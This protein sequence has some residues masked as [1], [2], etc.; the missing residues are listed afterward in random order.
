MKNTEAYLSEIYGGPLDDASKA[1]MQFF[2]ECYKGSLGATML[3]FGGGPA[4]YSVVSAARSCISIH[5]ADYSQANLTEIERWKS[6]GADAFDWRH[7]IHEALVCE[8][9][10]GIATEETVS[11]RER[12]IRIKL[13]RITKCDAFETDPLCGDGRDSYGVVA[14]NFCLEGIVR[15]RGAW[16]TLTRKLFALVG[17]RGQMVTTAIR[18]GRFWGAGGEYLPC[19]SIGLNDIREAYLLAGFDVLLARELDLPG[20]AGYDGILMV[21]G[22]RA[23]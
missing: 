23:G 3:E 19:V 11:D 4:L 15:D 20:R 9:K 18:N 6:N 1:L 2:A 10:I 7:F 22:R 14:N 12:L 8:R 21:E 16:T 17:A 5:F 13:D